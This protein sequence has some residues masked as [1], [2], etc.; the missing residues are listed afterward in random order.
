[1]PSFDSEITKAIWG[2]K[3]PLRITCLTDDASEWEPIHIEA[4][5]CSYFPLIAQK[6]HD[7][8][9]GLGLQVDKENIWFDYQGEPLKWHYPI[10]LLYD[11]NVFGTATPTMDEAVIP[12][13]I[14]IHWRHFPAD[15]LLRNPSIDAAQ[16]IFMSMLKEADYLRH[17]NTKKVMNLSKRDQTQLWQSL[18]VDDHDK[19]WEVNEHLLENEHQ[20][21]R[22]IPVRLYLPNNGVLQEAVPYHDTE[23]TAY[24]IADVI[25]RIMPKLSLTTAI[26]VMHGIPLTMDI[27]AEWA[28]KNL[29][30]ADNFLHIV[31]SKSRE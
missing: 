28:S 16:D 8:Y 18:S 6:L 13:C 17:G 25:S 14:N 24:T 30:Y 23:G 20:Q 26:P 1:M 27:P 31:L 29:A 22:H 5:R 3:L 21:W 7:I 9:T 11:L 15:K 4:P 19:Y 10:G 2:G 12:W